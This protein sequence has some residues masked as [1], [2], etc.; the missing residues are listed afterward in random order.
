[1]LL[2]CTGEESDLFE[3]DIFLT[4]GQ[5]PYDIETAQAEVAKRSAETSSGDYMEM[6]AD[7]R[8]DLWP[9]GEI[10]YIFDGSLGKIFIAENSCIALLI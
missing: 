5:W 8:D 4:D 9:R 1:L 6:L 2:Y 3:G 10:F 7:G